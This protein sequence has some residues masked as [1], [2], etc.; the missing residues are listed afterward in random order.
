MRYYQAIVALLVALAVLGGIQV[1]VQSVD[2]STLPPEVLP[3]WGA[4]AY[5]F[6]TQAATPFYTFLRNVLG[7]AE[8]WFGANPEER[9]QMSYE[10]GKLGETLARFE[11]YLL[12]YTA[13]IQ[14]L[15]M[16]TP[17][18]KYAAWIA[19]ALGL[20]TDLMRKSLKDLSIKTATP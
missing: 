18:Q 11:V 5:I 7:Y 2:A 9:E 1:W 3:L 13:A 4:I 15:T 16:G 17:L 20:V 6:T 19:G 10:A 14:A 8:N 12:G